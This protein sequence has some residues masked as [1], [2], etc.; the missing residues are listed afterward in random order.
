MSALVKKEIRLLLPLWIGALSLLV[1]AA[2]LL[3]ANIEVRFFAAG[4]CCIILAAA[5]YG[6]EFSYG[7]FSL[8][9]AQPAP[10]ERIWKAKAAVLSAALLSIALAFTICQKLA[11]TGPMN[12]Q[13]WLEFFFVLS[14]TAGAF[15]AG[16]V[17][18]QVFAAFWLAWL[19]P[20]EILVLSILGPGYFWSETHD[21]WVFAVVPLV[22]YAGVGV[23]WSRLSYFRAQDL[24]S[25][26]QKAVRLPC[27]SLA[28]FGH[29]KGSA[30]FRRNC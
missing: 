21:A 4:V 15:C 24:A 29:G 9:L 18:R 10:R 19:I 30:N 23:W 17:V 1:L 11:P 22:L 6:M 16:I 2:C 8:L 12:H 7:T 3:P 27:N 20:V 13:Q 26:G 28:L 5:S 25:E 14:A